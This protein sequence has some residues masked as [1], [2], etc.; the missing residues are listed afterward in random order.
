MGV[1]NA[2]ELLK[3]LD[4]VLECI[5]ADEIRAAH[6]QVSKLVEQI[7]KDND[8]P[9]SAGVRWGKWST[10]QRVQDV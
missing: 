3:R 2:V 1:I 8:M 5:E 10:A 7:E 9:P 4:Y 6:E